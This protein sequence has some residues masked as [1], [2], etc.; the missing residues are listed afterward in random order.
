ML[1][2]STLR[3]ALGSNLPAVL[4]TGDTAP[5]RLREARAVGV[6]V[7]HKPVSPSQLYRGLMNVLKDSEREK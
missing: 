2:R 3:A 7:L 6:P 5:Q 1:F 4:V